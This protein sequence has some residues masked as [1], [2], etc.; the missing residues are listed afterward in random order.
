MQKPMNCFMISIISMI[1][2]ISG[3]ASKKVGMKIS[4]RECQSIAKGVMI[5][6][7]AAM[8]NN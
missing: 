7:M 1:M 6:E 5:A 3:Q 8:V 4:S 2:T